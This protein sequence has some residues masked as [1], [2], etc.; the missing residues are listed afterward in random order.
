MKIK[1]RHIHHDIIKQHTVLKK[2]QILTAVGTSAKEA[3][4]LTQV[5]MISWTEKTP[6][7]RRGKLNS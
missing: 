2:N 6:E 7:S 5:K 3:I 4:P 1:L